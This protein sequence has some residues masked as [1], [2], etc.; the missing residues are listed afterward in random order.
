MTDDG[1]NSAD[2]DATEMDPSQKRDTTG[3]AAREDSDYTAYSSQS[4]TAGFDQ[5]RDLRKVEAEDRTPYVAVKVLGQ[6]FRGHPQS[7]VALQ[8]EAVKSQK[9]AHPNIVTV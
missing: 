9:L 4:Q 5:A 1:H 8:Q 2:D 7:F 6:G 3:S